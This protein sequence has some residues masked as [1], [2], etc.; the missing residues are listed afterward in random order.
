MSKADR[1]VSYDGMCRKEFLK[2]KSD[3]SSSGRK[4]LA[5]AHRKVE[6][7]HQWN[8]QQ[9]D[10]AKYMSYIKVVWHHRQLNLL[11]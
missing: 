8:I 1:A 9:N 7:L 5:A 10:G 4:V 3:S 11:F 6:N 2:K